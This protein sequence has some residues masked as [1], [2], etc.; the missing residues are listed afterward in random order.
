MGKKKRTRLG[1]EFWERDRENMRLL[2][3]RVAFHKQKLAEERAARE[4]E[5]PS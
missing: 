4:R 5:Q 2:K 1:P 3:E